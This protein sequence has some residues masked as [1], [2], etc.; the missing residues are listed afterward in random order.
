MT[1]FNQNKE[2]KG[3]QKSK[4]ATSII[5]LMED[6]KKIE[7]ANLL[8]TKEKSTKDISREK[9]LHFPLLKGKIEVEPIIR[10]KV[11]SLKCIKIK[12][13]YS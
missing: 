5:I 3:S 2:L 7:E 1:D 8:V 4:E 13:K 11:I 6:H 9:V 12:V 10:T